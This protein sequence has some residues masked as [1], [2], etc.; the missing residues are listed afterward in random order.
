MKITVKDFW[1][2]DN[3]IA[4]QEVLKQAS[5]FEIFMLGN[6]K[7]RYK[8]TGEIKTIKIIGCGTGREIESIAEFYKPVRI[9]ASDLS[10][11]MIAKCD[12]NLKKWNIDSFT[13]TLVL[14]AKDYN[15]VSE[16][17]DL[18]TILNSML[19]YVPLRADRLTIYKNAL[20]ILKPKGILIGT[21]HNQY[22]ATSKTFYF[23]LRNLFSFVLGDRVGNRDTGFK[24]FKVPGYY[25]DKK[26]LLKDLTEAGFKDVEIYSLE[27]YYASN[28]IAYDRKKGYNNLI[29][30][31]TKP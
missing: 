26:G 15:K 30:I 1:E 4:T 9:V 31:A 17:F 8:S 6:A 18:V 24:G 11:N 3:I 12:E 23:Q 10:Q 13:E 29:F 28:G 14:D 16:T 2:K 7:E 5:D 27:E 25:Y 22:G 20:Q 21:V 19:T